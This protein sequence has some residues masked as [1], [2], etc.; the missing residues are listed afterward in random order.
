L[1]NESNALL[2]PFF[3]YGRNVDYQK[4]FLELSTDK[5]DRKF[6]H[7]LTKTDAAMKKDPWKMQ[8]L[9]VIAGNRIKLKLLKI[10]GNY[11]LNLY[12]FIQSYILPN[13]INFNDR[14]RLYEAFK[15]DI[16][17]FINNEFI[18]PQFMWIHTIVNHLPYLPPD[19]SSVF[20]IKEINY[21]NYR[22]GAEFVNKNI[23]AKQK[24][25]Y[26]E[27]MKRTDRFLGDII[28]TLKSNDLLSDSLI[29]IT[30]DHGEEFME[31][32][33][34]QHSIVS[35]SD[36][37]LHVPLL[38]YSPDMLS[39][40]DVYTPVSTIDILPTICELLGMDIPDSN[41]GVSLKKHM[42]GTVNKEEN[43]QEIEERVLYS[44]SWDTPGMIDRKPGYNSNRKIFTVR[45]G[46]YKLRIIHNKGNNH[47]TIED[48][49]LTDWISGRK[50]EIDN[51]TSTVNELMSCYYKHLYQSEIS[52]K[53][54][55]TA[56]E[57]E[58]VKSKISNLK[59]DLKQ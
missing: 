9:R 41:Q 8:R 45:K 27:S 16:L 11:G 59:K 33:Y 30:A 43:L 5:H 57:K 2:S 42:F 58:R 6:G 29:I 55:M 23:C 21:L 24:L 4:H 38:F 51:N 52:M 17:S 12:R 19:D 49:E 18:S 47:R 44:E 32:D 25:L 46:Q 54:T 39:P 36:T 28:D 53:S 37:L 3:G 48:L 34:F 1:I 13:T 15:D 56:Q 40:K 7:T 14:R 22:G 26:I 10:I 31:E 35:S 20:D 50:L